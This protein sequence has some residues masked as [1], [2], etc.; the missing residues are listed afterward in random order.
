[1]SLSARRSAFSDP[2]VQFGGAS[3]GRR[4]RRRCPGLISDPLSFAK[5]GQY[6]QGVRAFLCARRKYVSG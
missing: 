1:M 6:R 5:G 3:M 2:D 4:F